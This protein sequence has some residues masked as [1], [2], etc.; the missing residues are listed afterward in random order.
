MKQAKLIPI[1]AGALVVLLVFGSLS[2]FTDIFPWSKNAEEDLNYSPSRRNDEDYDKSEAAVSAVENHETAAPVEPPSTEPSATDKPP[3]PVPEE[4]SGV[5]SE[6]DIEE[7]STATDAVNASF[8]K[9]YVGRWEGSD[10]DTSI[11][12]IVEANGSGFYALQQGSYSEYYD[13]SLEAGADAFSVYVPENNV[14]GILSINGTY[15]YSYGVLT[16]NVHSSLADGR[17]IRRTIPCRRIMS[18][19]EINAET[20]IMN[21]DFMLGEIREY[22]VVCLMSDFTLKDRYANFIVTEANIYKEDGYINLSVHFRLQTNKINDDYDAT[23]DIEFHRSQPENC[24]IMRN[25]INT[26]AA[27]EIFSSY[28]DIGDFAIGD[29]SHLRFIRGNVFVSVTGYNDVDI[30]DLARVIDLQVL[31]I[32]NR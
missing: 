30:D 32:L 10:G 29:I 31:D 2:L 24:A 3:T 11:S 9:E 7:E 6:K 15:K 1:A 25:S 13:F 27:M 21:I 22:P 12:F 26:Y 8:P 23:V 4:S 18:L 19:R 20:G 14:S 17:E 16:L 28:L 5:F